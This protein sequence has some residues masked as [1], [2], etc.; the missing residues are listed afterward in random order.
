MLKRQPPTSRTFSHKTKDD[1]DFLASDMGNGTWDD[2]RCLGAAK[3]EICNIF[4]PCKPQGFRGPVVAMAHLAFFSIVTA[5]RFPFSDI[6]SRPQFLQRLRALFLPFLFRYPHALLVCHLRA[7]SLS[8]VGRG[9]NRVLTIF[10]STAPPRKTMCRR[11]GGSSM[12]TLNFCATVV[13]A[14]PG[15]VV[16]YVR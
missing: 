10:A 3:C 8:L 11:R 5:V 14:G 7:L 15:G 16:A 13:S 12:R 6:S 4:F 2:I 9:D 1:A